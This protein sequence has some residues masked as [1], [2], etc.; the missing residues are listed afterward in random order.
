[1][2]WLPLQR[3]YRCEQATAA[4]STELRK[5]PH[6]CNCRGRG[7]KD[8]TGQ[9]PQ[10]PCGPGSIRES[11]SASVYRETCRF[12]ASFMARF[13]EEVERCTEPGQVG[14]LR[15]FLFAPVELAS[16]VCRGLQA[17][18]LFSASPIAGQFCVN[19][20]GL[21]ELLVKWDQPS[22]LHCRRS[23]G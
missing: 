23:P 1:M 9:G 8:V 18:S 14:E 3:F 17:P 2:T 7:E 15:L 4:V 12:T 11:F 20:G 13:I 6:M 22:R 19:D 5:L 21:C 10:Q 16:S